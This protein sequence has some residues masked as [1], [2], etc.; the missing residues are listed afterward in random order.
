MHHQRGFI[1]FGVLIAILVGLAVIGGGAYYAWQNKQ[2]LQT[3][4]RASST[5]GQTSDTVIISGTYGFSE[6]TGFGYFYTNSGPFGRSADI[7]FR[8][9]NV[10]QNVP[11]GAVAANGRPHNAIAGGLFPRSDSCSLV[12]EATVE[13]GNPEPAGKTKTGEDIVNVD[14]IR[15]VKKD[16][17][18]DQC[19]DLSTGEKTETERK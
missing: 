19:V 2:I 10:I 15:V 14:F 1:G 4:N 7:V 6:M 12:I 9:S 8:E 18:I 17:I 11:A 3:S 13:V 16:R 5:Q